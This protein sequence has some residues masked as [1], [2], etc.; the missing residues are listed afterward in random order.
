MWFVVVAVAVVV[1]VVVV[2][3][4]DPPVLSITTP[5][6]PPPAAVM[7]VVKLFLVLYQRIGSTNSGLM[8]EFRLLVGIGRSGVMIGSFCLNM[9]S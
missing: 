5:D 2:G 7:L 3:G 9:V 6:R 1:A 8:T 4:R